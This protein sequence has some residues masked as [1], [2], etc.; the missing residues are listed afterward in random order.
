MDKN[1]YQV[2]K[3]DELSGFCDPR[4]VMVDTVSGA[5]V[6]DAQG[7]GYKSA[8]KAYAAWNYK[9]KSPTELKKTAKTEKTIRKWCDNN[10]RLTE[11]M[12]EIIL[13][14]LKMFGRVDGPE[15]LSSIRELLKQ[16]GL[17]EKNLPFTVIELLRC[18]Q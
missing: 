8:Q 14:C 6:D 7:Y 11:N 17:T 12:E 9:T 18:Y 16:N 3:S 2:A 10:K 4:F 15:C 5:V 13:R 1:R